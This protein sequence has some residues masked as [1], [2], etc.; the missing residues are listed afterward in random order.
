MDVRPGDILQMKKHIHAEAKPFLFCVPEWILRF[1]V[2]PAA[3]KL[4]FQ[5]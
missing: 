3:M 4:W 2:P 5:G 1:A